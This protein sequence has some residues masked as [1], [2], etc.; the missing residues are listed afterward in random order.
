MAAIGCREGSGKG[1]PKP[2]GGRQGGRGIL[3]S[4]AAEKALK[5]LL[6]ALK[7]I[8]RKPTSLGGCSTLLETT[9]AYPRRISTVL[10]PL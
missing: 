4:A 9:S 7:A 1:D 10:L 2:S 6:L 8:F 3:G 5:A